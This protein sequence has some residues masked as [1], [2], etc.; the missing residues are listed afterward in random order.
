L[1]PT[2]RGWDPS[3]DLI[4]EFP[5]EALGRCSS[6]D[7]VAG[8]K[9]RRCRLRRK[10]RVDT[11]QCCQSSISKCYLFPHYTSK[12]C[13]PIVFILVSI[14]LFYLD[15]QKADNGVTNANTSLTTVFPA[16]I[17]CSASKPSVETNF[18]KVVVLMRT[19]DGPCA[20]RRC[21]WL[22]T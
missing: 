5:S 19:F 18:Q 14:K 6:P 12:V 13:C 20:E 10:A 9:V 8:G 2:I 3:H 11:I 16:W 4:L 1:I 21:L 22:G 17:E 7:S 15:W